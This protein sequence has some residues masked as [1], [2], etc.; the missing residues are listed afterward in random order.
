MRE[1]FAPQGGPAAVPCD[2]ASVEGLVLPVGT[3]WLL[4]QAEG[5]SGQGL[6]ILQPH[7]APTGMGGRSVSQAAR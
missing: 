4:I 5:L 7:E 2:V 1:K 3:V 6:S